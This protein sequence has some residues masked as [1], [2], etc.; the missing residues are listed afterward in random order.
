MFRRLNTY[1]LFFSAT[2][3]KGNLYITIQNHVCDLFTL[4]QKPD[5]MFL[6]HTWKLT[7]RSLVTA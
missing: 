3:K 6:L 7:C 4:L 1:E 2:I 5:I